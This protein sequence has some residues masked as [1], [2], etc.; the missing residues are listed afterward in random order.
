ME[1][2]TLRL[3]GADPVWHLVLNRPRMH[4]A[5]N[6]QVLRDLLE[7][8]GAI[9]EL[10]DCRCVILRGEGPSFSSG[11]DLKEGLTHAGTSGDLLRRARSGARVIDALA[12]LTPVTIA[13][14]HGFAI[15]G[16]ACLAMACDFR[17]GARSAVVAIREVNLG[18]SL[19]WHSIPNV[20][21]LVGPARA[22]EMILFGE[23]HPAQQMLEYGFFQQVVPDEKLLEAALALAD[24]VVRRPPLAVQMGKA[25][26]NAAVKALDR[27]VFHLDEPGVT[28]TGLSRDAKTAI[29]AIGSGEQPV[30]KKE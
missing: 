10:P 26:I 25:S 23:D 11:A 17:I 1:W 13:A 3:E 14:V 20:I 18:L 2:E 29:A 7:A 12:E 24:K 8:C 9:E 15:G 6:R 28:F 5:I 30:W 21:H 22:R 27:A 4:N 16:G 19:S